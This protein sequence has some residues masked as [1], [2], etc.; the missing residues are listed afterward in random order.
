MRVFDALMGAG[1]HHAAETTLR[2]AAIVAYVDDT[3][4]LGM[5]EKKAMYWAVSTFHEGF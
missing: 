1:R 3:L 4:D 5:I 2:A